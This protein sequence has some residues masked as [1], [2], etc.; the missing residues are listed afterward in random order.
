MEL[1]GKKILFLGDSITE[2]CGASDVSK[3]FVSLIAEKEGA[4]CVNYG[5]GG[6]RIAR[7]LKPSAESIWDRD[8]LSRVPEMDEEA[9]VVVVFGGTNDFGHGDTPIGKF[10]D[11]CV[12]SF[13]GAL[14]M[15]Y[16]ALI[17]KYP[18]ADIVVL[19]PLHRLN[20]D[21][22]YGD[23]FKQVP[24]APLKKYVEI[25]KEVAEYYYNVDNIDAHLAR[26]MDLRAALDKN[27][28]TL[29]V[30]AARCGDLTVH[31]T[32][33]PQQICFC[34]QYQCTDVSEAANKLRDTYIAAAR[35]GK[36]SMVG[37]MFTMRMSQSLDNLDLLCCI[38]ME[39][40]FDGPERMEFA[41]TPALCIY[42]RGPYE[43]TATALRALMEYVKEYKIETT[44]S[45]RSIYME[46]PPSRSENSSDYITQIAVPIKL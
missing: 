4:E 36:M 41:E 35:T 29:Q 20:E 43:G 19:T 32:T 30:R 26:L 5:I 17:E 22:P 18:A 16:I 39:S 25:V 42:Y 34:R 27:I 2:G 7:Q 6:T 28:Q 46:G 11:R 1:K 40:S 12:H 13:Y 37:R 24:T 15:L 38:P 45:F 21:N 31:K 23:G 44:G 14:H 10:E 8:Y 9:D 3:C 33:L